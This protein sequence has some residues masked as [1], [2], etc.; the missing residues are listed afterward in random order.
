MPGKEL[1]DGNPGM[2]APIGKRDS[3]RLYYLRASEAGGNHAL[4][5]SEVAKTC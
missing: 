2:R 5:D 1:V 4:A 3:P